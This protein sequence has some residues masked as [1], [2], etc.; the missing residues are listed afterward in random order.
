MLHSLGR[1]TIASVTDLTPMG[2]LLECHERIRA[3][4]R[5]GARLA[6][7]Q[8]ASA[9]E[10][11]E[12][13]GKVVRYF[14]LAFPMHEKDEEESVMPRLKNRAPNLSALITKLEGEHRALDVLIEELIAITQRLA[15]KGDRL[16]SEREPLARV[17]T[18]LD[19][20]FNAHFNVE[21]EVVLGA[22]RA[23][24]TEEDLS[25]I[26][27]EMQERRVQALT[28]QSQGGHDV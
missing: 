24:L 19:T 10:V 4:M 22:M 21:E 13:A 11:E 3:F 15:E 25:S 23:H 14:T 17:I 1:K 2:A 20:G 12:T 8:G 26:T 16:P 27:A 28:R 6:E 18:Q 5:L 7:V 9:A